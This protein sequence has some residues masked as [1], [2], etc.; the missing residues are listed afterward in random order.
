MVIDGVMAVE[1]VDRRYGLEEERPILVANANRG[2]EGG[3]ER[4]KN[5]ELVAG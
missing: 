3:K 5:S 4:G 1:I 2:D